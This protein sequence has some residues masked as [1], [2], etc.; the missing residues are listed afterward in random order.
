MIS[1]AEVEPALRDQAYRKLD[2]DPQILLEG[3]SRFDVDADLF[4]ARLIGFEDEIVEDGVRLTSVQ[5]EIHVA[6]PQPLRLSDFAADEPIVG[7]EPT[8]RAVYRLQSGFATLSVD[9]MYGPPVEKLRKDFTARIAYLRYRR[10][11]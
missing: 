8:T 11:S 9:G 7:L 3:D 10:R 6:I 1:W 4:Y 5:P 2:T